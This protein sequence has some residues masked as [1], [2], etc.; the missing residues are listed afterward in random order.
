[1]DVDEQPTHTVTPPGAQLPTHTSRSGRIIKPSGIYRD[2]QYYTYYSGEDEVLC[3]TV[4][5][6]STC[7]EI[8]EP[9]TLEE[10]LNSPQAEDWRKAM[11]AEMAALLANQT[12]TLVKRSHGTAIP[13][14][15]VF[16]VKRNSTG[17]IT[18]FK[19]RLV[20]KGFKQVYEVDYVEISAP[21]ARLTSI[22]AVFALAAYHNW[23]LIHFDIDTAFLHGVL[24]EEIYM[25]QPPC[26]DNGD[27]D[28]VCLLNKCLYGLKQA[29]LV[30]HKTLKAP[31]MT[32]TTQ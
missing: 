19:C 25:M 23:E 29:P 2:T 12:W 14:K 21:V 26:F 22:R 9:L 3:F 30:W 4:V 7:T 32:S 11:N 5:T 24:D 20:A 8:S 31:S 18:R 6:D 16:K 1:M 13:C 15:W 28:T 17:Q 27:P 10:A